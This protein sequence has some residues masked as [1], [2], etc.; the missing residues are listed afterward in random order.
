[1]F[2]I[3]HNHQHPWPSY[4]WQDDCPL[5]MAQEAAPALLEACEELKNHLEEKPEAKCMMWCQLL[6]DNAVSLARKGQ[7]LV[8]NLD[9]EAKRR[10]SELDENKEQ[11]ISEINLLRPDEVDEFL[12]YPFGR[13]KKLA[14]KNKIPY[15]LLPDGEI[16][17]D[18]A[19]IIKLL[20]PNG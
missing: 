9:E 14:K 20:K 4:S 3:E 17:F 5:C 12:R 15:I 7:P 11:S 8:D 10:F 19:E 18:K 6:I 13:S 2:K 1:M 16:R